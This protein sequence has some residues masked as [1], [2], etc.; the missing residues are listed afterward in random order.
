MT[1]SLLPILPAVDDVLFDFAQSD[2]FWANLSIAFGTSYD[3][4]KATELRQQWQSRNF[5]QIPPIEVLS[6]E[7]LGT[8]NGAYSSSTNKIYLSASFLNT[9]SSAAIVK[10]ILE[11][12]GHYVDAQI[13]QVDSAGDEGEIFANLVSGK[14]L[15]PTE[16]AQLKGENDHAVINLGGQAVEIEMAFSFGTTG[17]RQFGTSGG[18]SGSGVS[19]DSYGNI[20]VTGYTNGSLPGNTN[21]GNNDF[22]VAKYDVYGNRLWVK[23]FGS[24][25]A[26]YATGISSESSGNTYVS[27]RTEGGEDAF[28]AKYNANGNQLWMAQFGTSGYDSATGVSSDG[29]GNVYVSGYTDGSFPSYT[30]LGSYDAFVAKYDTSGNPVWVK[31]F[32]TSSHDYA[33]GI[34]SDSNGN[35]YVSG[36]TFGSFLGYTNL[37]LYDAFVAK[38]D[39]NGNQ[40]WLRQFGTSGD[41]EITGI[42]SDS[43]DNVYV[44]G[45]TKGGLPGYSNLGSY[46]AFVAKYDGNGNQLWLRQFGTSGNDEITGISRDIDNNVYVTGYTTGSLPGNINAGGSDAFVAKYNANGTLNWVRQFGTSAA[47]SANGI[48]IDSSGNVYVTGDTSGGLPGNSNSG[49]SDAFVVGF[50]S[51][52]NILNNIYSNNFETSAGS[53][54]SKTNRSTTPIGGR[55]FLGEFS[56]DTVSLTLNNPLLN[57]NTVT[58]EFDL[59]IIRTWDGNVLGDNFTLTTSNGQ[60]LVNTNF[61]FYNSNFD[62]SYSQY[63][64]WGT[65][66]Y[67][68]SAGQG[69]YSPGT[70]AVENNTLGYQ[71]YYDFPIYRYYT[72]DSVYHLTSTFTNTA[73]TL[74]LN[75]TGSNLQGLSDESW[76]IDNI[77]VRVL[78]VPTITLAVSPASVTEDGTSNLIY[79]FTRTGSTTNPLTV[80]FS[81]GGTA[82]NGTDYASIP[83]GVIFA[84]NSAT[85]TVIVDPTPDTT[86][87]SNETVILTLA[88]GTGYT[89]GTTTA[90]TGTITNVTLP[91]ITLAVS[92]SSVTEDGTQNLIYTFTRTGSTTNPL[93][94]NY[95][96]AGTATNGTDYASIPTSVTFVAGSATAT[97]IVDPT[98]DTT[99]ESNETV[100]LTLATGTG[101]TVGTTTAVTGTITNVTL[102]T[103]TL[104]VSPSSVTEDGTQN[105]IYT[106]TRS[107]S[108]TNPLTVNYTV[109]GTA[110]NGTDYASIP[111]G[112]IFA[113]NSATATVIVDPTPDT[114][115]ES[116]ETVILTLA[117]GTGYTV[118]TTTAVTGTITNVPATSVTSQ[119]SINDITVVEGQNSNAILTVT[120]NNPNPQQITVNYTTAPIDATANVDYTSQTG[121][122]TIAANTSTATIS[123][124][125]LNDNLNEP[126]EAF[127]V[128]LSNAV[129]ATINPDEAIGQVIITD[130]LQSA[131]TR[132]LPNNVENL[133]LIG[134]NNINGTGNASDNKITGNSGNNILAGANGNDIYCFNAS[135]QL[136]S[137]TIQET[138]TGGIDTLDFTGTNTAVRVNLG[139]TAVQ[140]VVTNN[141]KL[142]F[143]ANNTIEN[144]IGDS[145]NDR[146]TGNSLN[147][148]LTGGGGND[149][150]TGQDGNDSLIGGSGDD[151]LT[152][153]NGSD[154]FIFNSSNL[155]IDAISD[156]TPGSDK[157]VLS[158]AIFPALQSSIGNGFSQPAEFAS[159]ADD[160][161]VATSSAF[162]VYSTSSGSIYYNQNGSAAGLGN[163]SEFANLLTVPTLTA[164]NFTLI[165]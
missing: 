35:V 10:V 51:D 58:V 20:Y 101:Y 118:G 11:E 24:V 123:I 121:T 12:I 44:T 120:V 131:S 85:A 69:N 81:I 66:S 55:K 49:S 45:S 48:R 158:K 112:V 138:T 50:D 6:D 153:G 157:I 130:T 106:F 107:G 5:S 132:T 3:L 47:D 57:N 30:N 41:D 163:G 155:G 141:L 29:S 63:G 42:S 36:K 33:E 129:N 40:L 75:F 137:D 133:R 136:G 100:I 143:S 64:Y 119:L 70:G 103:I 159:V 126:D 17:Y 128:T 115:A 147:N 116:N 28:V 68:N 21:F 135:T 92:P 26:D 117:T 67:P 111:A 94:V 38:Y 62:N 13:N 16:L 88:T 149:Q 139:T 23:Q 56:N 72:T 93:T 60:T 127:T 145:G 61:Y 108:T 148:T 113:A 86:A 105:L 27:G 65:Q 104:A 99:A 7:V 164:A 82:T 8:A 142:T 4:V 98:P 102:P 134:S 96:V 54:W 59:F 89:I 87:E 154:N 144:I 140:T 18:D 146:L 125:L 52:G 25:Y 122:L 79:T 74:T 31:Q 15:T 91:T 162:I 90:V 160:D 34:S 124:P 14:S 37:G 95:S 109:G 84:A 22:F 110:T 39:G 2:G 161:L 97:V 53:E 77:S 151:L 165:N 114:T 83:A 9:A 80:N 1:S 152:G 78:D 150:L 43:S 19:S 71:F 73:N 76:G 156:F 32:S 46:D